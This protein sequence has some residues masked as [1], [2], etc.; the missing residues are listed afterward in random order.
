M[1]NEASRTVRDGQAC[2]PGLYFIKAGPA[3]GRGD[4]ALNEKVRGIPDAGLSLRSASQ[5]TVWT[6]SDSRTVRSIYCK[7]SSQPNCQNKKVGKGTGAID[8]QNSQKGNGGIFSRRRGWLK[9]GNKLKQPTVTIGCVNKSSPRRTLFLSPL[10]RNQST[11]IHPA[12]K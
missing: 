11:P 8:R 3:S 2:Q 1:M 12:M 10:I 6:L 5:K 7:I 9:K 4:R